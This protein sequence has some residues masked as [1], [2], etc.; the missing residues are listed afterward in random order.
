[1]VPI[2]VII[3]LAIICLGLIV[4]IHYLI[5][6]TISIEDEL[7]KNKEDYYNI[8]AERDYI[9]QEISYIIDI[10]DNSELSINDDEYS[11]EAIRDF[12]LRFDTIKQQYE[13]ID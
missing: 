8:K 5:N 10:Y 3:I 12:L 13:T 1:M 4:L 9:E 2:F 6:R 11:Y 7:F